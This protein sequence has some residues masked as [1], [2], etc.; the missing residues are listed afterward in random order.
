MLL[1]WRRRLILGEEFE[2]EELTR[3]CPGVPKTKGSS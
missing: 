1:A 2:A 3:L